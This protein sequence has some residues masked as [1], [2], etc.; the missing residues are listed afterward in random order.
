M[1]LLSISRAVAITG[2]AIAAVLGSIAPAHATTDSLTGKK[3]VALGDSYASG[4]GLP[5]YNATPSLGCGQSVDDVPH[6]IAQTYGL[7]L[8]DVTCAGAGI[9]NVLSTPQTVAGGATVPA[10]LNAVT[11]DT[12]VVSI[13]IGGNDLG[14]TTVLPGCAANSPQG[15]LLQFPVA[16]CQMKYGSTLT[17]LLQTTISP[18]YD[19]LLAAIRQKAPQAKIILLGYPA[20]APT[21]ANTPVGGCFAS[22]LG[23]PL[24]QNAFPF[25]DVDRAY[26]AGLSA[27]LDETERDAAA[28]N[29]VTFV[30]NLAAT[31]AHTPCAGNPDSYLNG[32]SLT[33]VAPPAIAEGALHPNAAGVDFL[34]AQLATALDAA[35]PATPPATGDGD[36]AT[37]AP[38]PVEPDTQAA[39]P[40]SAG[41]ANELA[42]TGS[43]QLPLAAGAVLVLALGA[44]L[45]TVAQRRKQRRTTSTN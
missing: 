31:D 4:Y 18:A 33:S 36:G 9:P 5:P 23:A 45:I 13:M 39:A 10:Q 17:S 42:A 28:R 37:A 16:N 44:G 19:A 27:A 24:P 35:F 40:A 1:P 20:L 11:P 21:D 14:F 30:S 2:V 3:Y 38:S 22:A 7:A 43:D 6:R 15:P 34:E 25:T 26:I 8:T 12:A 32:V 29:G 41:S